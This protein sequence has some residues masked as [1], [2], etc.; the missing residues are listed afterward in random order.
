MVHCSSLYSVK[1][2]EPVGLLAPLRLM[3]SPA[4][5][6]SPTVPV[7]GLAVVEITKRAAVAGSGLVIFWSEMSVP[8]KIRFS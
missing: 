6:V 3:L 8:A 2:T 4:V 7:V 5:I 1:V